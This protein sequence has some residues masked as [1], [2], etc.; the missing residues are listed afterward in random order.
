[1]FFEKMVNPEIKRFV[2][3][4]LLVWTI[5]WKSVS[6]SREAIRGH[7]YQRVYLTR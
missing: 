6:I 2:K 5:F 4:A 3:F 1:M 7:L